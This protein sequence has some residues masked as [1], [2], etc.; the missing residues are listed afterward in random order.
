MVPATE[1]MVVVDDAG[2][3]STVGSVLFEKACSAASRMPG[4]IRLAISVSGRE[5]ESDGLVDHVAD[6]LGR[7]GVLARRIE[8]QLTESSAISDRAMAGMRG[9]A[10]L[11]VSLTV[12]EFGAGFSS[13]ASLSD[14]PFT[15][16]RVDRSFSGTVRGN[17][18]FL[19]PL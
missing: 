5:L 14:L 8:L 1:F 10:G 3:S 2:L 9:V 19:P 7:W 16:V 12:D 18:R 17:G 15:R 6:A 4:D 13:L 11:G